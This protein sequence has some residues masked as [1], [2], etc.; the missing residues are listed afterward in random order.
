MIIYILIF[1]AKIVEI[2]FMTIR[3]VLMT[4]GEKLYASILG[5]FEI[6]IWI[7]LM[8]TILTNIQSDPLQAVSYALG[9]ACGIYLGSTIEERIGVGLV[10]MHVIADIRDGMQIAS[11]LRAQNIAV[12]HLKGEGRDAGKSILMIHIKRRKRKEAVKLIKEICPEAM[13]N[14]YDVKNIAGGY[15][16]KK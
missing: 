12:T 7:Y 15:G 8:S 2:S 16:L 1:T 5:M 10:T 14:I 6:S 11:G 3:T 13:I 4:K 9:F